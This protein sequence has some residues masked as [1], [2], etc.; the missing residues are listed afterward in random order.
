MKEKKQQKT[1]WKS[2]GHV[3]LRALDP[4]HKLPAE[5]L[6]ETDDAVEVALTILEYHLGFVELDISAITVATPIG[7]VQIERKHL[8]HIVEKRQDARERYVRHAL[9][10]MKD[11]LEVWLV[12]YEDGD[13]NTTCRHAYIGAFE[14]KHHML[15]VFAD[16]NGK[17]LWNF[18]HGDGKAMNKHRH[19]ECVYRRP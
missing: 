16:V 15:V 17:I 10:T 7:D 9:V 6:I 12:E 18:M 14:G 2:C 8:G 13:G 5:V 3:D 19:G 1:T 11:P 4:A